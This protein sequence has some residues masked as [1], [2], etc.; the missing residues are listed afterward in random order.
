MAEHCADDEIYEIKKC[1]FSL[2]SYLFHYIIFFPVLQV[3][4]MTFPQNPLCNFCLLSVKTAK[5]TENQKK[6]ALFVL[7]KS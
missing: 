5:N 3:P 4:C 6:P 1:S 7:T 2:S